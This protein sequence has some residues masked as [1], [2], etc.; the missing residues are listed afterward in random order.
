MSLLTVRTLLQTLTGRYDLSDANLDQMIQFGQSEL[1][2]L[3]DLTQGLRVANFSLAQSAYQKE[4]TGV[5]S[6]SDIYLK[7]S[8]GVY[9]VRDEAN[10]HAPLERREYEE[11][12]ID[13][14]DMASETEGVPTEWTLDPNT[15]TTGFYIRLSPPAD[16]TYTLEVHGYLRQGALSDDA[17]TNAWT[18]LYPNVLVLAATRQIHLMRNGNLELADAFYAQM[19][20]FLQGV[21]RNIAAFE[22]IGGTELPG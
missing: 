4:I 3:V 9:V 22:D 7:D 13:H 14:T 2:G 21:D 1:E 19:L 18:E 5:I 8:D 10:N 17:D 11:F 12:A 20:R 6:I 15:S 16:G